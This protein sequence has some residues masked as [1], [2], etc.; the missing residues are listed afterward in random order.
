MKGNIDILI[1]EGGVQIGS[2][3]AEEKSEFI[4]H[5]GTDL[6]Q[7][8]I[9]F[10]AP[11]KPANINVTCYIAEDLLFFKDIILPLQTAN[12]KEAVNFQ[13]D[14]LTPFDG[15]MLHS[16]N[17]I[18]HDDG[19][20]V[21]LYAVLAENVVPYL[22]EVAKHDCQLVGL[23]PE[24]QRFVTPL[25]KKKQKWALL[26]LIFLLTNIA[27]EIFPSYFIYNIAC[28]PDCISL[29]STCKNVPLGR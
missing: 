6:G 18:R 24:S 27:Y 16:F 12:I 13:L 9:R 19:F 11:Q 2:P 15:E 4:A 22:D 28:Q 23:F 8:I 10:C 1:R 21:A 14:L 7:R 20:H 17:T 29:F 3:F 5:P 25:S 26:L